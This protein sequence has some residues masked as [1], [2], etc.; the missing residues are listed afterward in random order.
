ASVDESVGR[1]LAK[2]EELGIAE[3]T[4][5]IFSSDNGG[6]G[7]Y[8]RVGLDKKIGIT[9]NAPL[10]GGKGTLYEGGVR[11]PYVFR[12]KGTVKPGQTEST[13]INSVDLYPTLVELAGGELPADYPL[14]GVSY[15]S[16]LKEQKPL[17]RGK[18]LFW[19]FPGYLGATAD[20]W[21][22]TPVSV[23]R[24]G[25]WKLL[26]YLE[27]GHLELYNLRDDL[28]ETNNLA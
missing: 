3:N 7:G 21:R 5:V 18:P 4:L 25:D 23:V 28:S 10:K 15:A 2:L 1:V 24:D 9:D 13:P 22:T 11:V 26:E 27:D 20:T 6:V 19:H 8:D 16:L 12:W 14:D 17:E